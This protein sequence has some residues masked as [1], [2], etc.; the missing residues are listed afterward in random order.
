[1]QRYFSYICVLSK[2]LTPN[3]KL[4]RMKKFLSILAVSAV[5][6][7]SAYAVATE[8]QDKVKAPPRGPVSTEKR[9][10]IA[11]SRAPIT[12]GAD[13][14]RQLYG[15]LEAGDYSIPYDYDGIVKI[16][17]GG[18][19]KEVK[20]LDPAQTACYFTRDGAGYVLAVGYGS[21]ITYTI[22]EAD[23]W[24][25]STQWEYTQ[26]SPAVLP[27]D[28]AFDPDTKR[29]Y[30]YFLN[31]HLAEGEFIHEN[32]GGKLGYLDIKNLN[33]LDAVEYVGDM[34]VPMRGMSFDSTGQLYGIG[35]DGNLYK[36]NKLNGSLTLVGAIEWEERSS[37]SSP[38]GD[39]FLHGHESAEFD[40]DTNE[41]YFSG[42]DE[43]W[44]TYIS[45]ID[46]A[47]AKETMIGD[48]GYETGGS[49]GCEMF[50]GIF[51][52]Q[53]PPESGSQPASVADLK[54]VPVG[55]SLN[56]T[57]AFTIPSTDVDGNA[58]DGDLY[59]EITDGETVFA[60]GTA[61]DGTSISTEVAVSEAGMYGLSVVLTYNGAK[62]APA[63]V[64]LFIGP[65][66]PVLSSLPDV[67]PNDN[68]V[69]ILWEDAESL[70]GGNLDPLTYK[71]V[72][73]P[74]GKV[75]SEGKAET[76]ATDIVESDLKT[77]CT[78]EVT[79]SAGAI[80]GETVVSRPIYVGKYFTLPYTDN[81]EDAL[82]FKQYPALDA[83]IDN[84]T[85]WIDTR[86]GAA[87][88]SSTVEDNADDYL[89]IG[90]FKL[91]AGTN[92]T[93]RMTA[94]GHS[95]MERVA[96]YVGTDPASKQS[97]DNCIVE[98]TVINPVAG[99]KSLTGTF[100]PDKT[101]SYWFGI[102]ACSDANAKDLYIYDVN[103][104]GQTNDTPAAPEFTYVPAATG[105]EFTIT[106]PRYTIS[107]DAA[108]RA[109]S[110]RIYRNNEI[111]GEVT[112][113]VTDGASVKF[114]DNTEGLT[115][116]NY[117]YSI[118]AVNAAGEGLARSQEIWVGADVPGKPHNM[119]VCEDINTPGLIHVTWEAPV[120]GANGGYYDPSSV[121]Y[122]V[123]WLSYGAGGSGEKHV[124]GNT[125]V[126]IELPADALQQQG[127]IAISVNASNS[128]GS[129]NIDS[130]MTRSCYYGPALDLPLAETF[131][132]SKANS[133]I[134]SGES[135]VEK[136]SLFDSI[137][138]FSSSDSQDSDGS[139]MSLS[140]FAAGGGYRIRTPRVDISKAENPIL[141]F[142][143]MYTAAASDFC[144]EIA[145][146]DQPFTTLKD[147][148]LTAAASDQWTRYTVPLNEFKDAKYVQFAF[149]GHA[150]YEASAFNNIDNVNIL[151]NTDADLKV[152]SITAPA[153][154]SVNDPLEIS[155]S[156]R[157]ASTKDVATG[158]YKVSL[159]KNGKQVSVAEEVGIRSFDNA[160]V[161]FLDNP[162]PTDP[163]NSVYSVKVDFESDN[164]PAD[165]ASD[166]V[167]V[168]ISV[169]NYP[170]PAN[171]TAETRS[172]VTLNWTAPDLSLI[173]R[174]SVTEGFDGYEPF[175]ISNIGEWTTYDKDGA[176]TVVMATVLGPYDYP[177]IGEP[178]AWQVM[179]PGAANIIN[180]AWYARSGEQMIVSFQACRDGGRDVTSN[181]WL[182]SPE[183]DT[184]AQTIS[185]YA[186][187]GMSSYAPELMDIYVSSTGKAVEDFTPLAE[188]V[189]VQH[190]KDW[191]EFEY[192]LPEGT[193]YFAIVHK[194]FDKLALLI[195]DITFVPA[196]SKYEDITLEGYRVY[197]DGL[198]I[199]YVEAGKTSYVD[200]KT[201]AGKS[202]TYHVT[203]V[204][205][206]GESRVSNAATAVSGVVD[207]FVADVRVSSLD[208]VIT[209]TG[210]EGMPVGVYTVDGRLV[211]ETP[212]AAV[213]RIPVDA[214]GVYIVRAGSSLSKIIVR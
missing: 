81:F 153:K 58:I 196:G 57:V 100:V 11:A 157:N 67:F 128:S 206:K 88:Y 121:T 53:A 211:A 177:H 201:E 103:I 20:A 35:Y 140:T 16:D 161:T 142:H 168:R 208:R 209:V 52:M 101:D 163:E 73:M 180:G 75:V 146:D 192:K 39:G 50:G 127:V 205:D 120:A 25:V 43:Y 76:E 159:Y 32:N 24:S 167:T 197:R 106:V 71:V 95:R 70:N 91:D 17:A 93:F 191:I 108:A 59:W 15:Y 171:L 165:N 9:A 152:L 162:V 200:T 77:V 79:P 78:Y 212:G 66:T 19:H 132:G 182:I 46:I 187:V 179:N 126:D 195:D 30:G 92:Y 138:D 109:T 156:I 99:S 181:D 139:M 72:R 117:V 129:A 21:T 18:N 36:I 178:M 189:E 110:V 160:T 65:D 164:N 184:A 31:N 204:W 183:L 148:D 137:W 133:G 64:N 155:V 14:S 90:P 166:E 123:D 56:A 33:V 51:F 3:L 69:T 125:S 8:L 61:A 118:A 190:S 37:G 203:A 188:N 105:P 45:K 4:R 2:T 186:R 68:E 145:V 98:E 207:T 83:N 10:A 131:A 40:W 130:R 38:A 82:L 158:E 214:D 170:A 175:I 49:E 26:N 12:G 44:D 176:P 143:H 97:F 107:G 102:H 42:M 84:N 115:A 112:D 198:R 111:V 5:V 48:F 1:M 47:T 136:E 202:Y 89:C 151:D 141:V 147:I 54:I 22:Y 134:W 104:T 28:L 86:R 41:L 185:F 63:T 29:V 122:M 199:D 74:D 85:W 119:R 96:A 34:S 124:G 174:E 6:G 213:T 27:Y 23:T 150:S 194:S 210:A 173:G 193:K 144:V 154:V 62:S 169:P 113:G 7:A 87:V 60:S 116:G 149:S 13:G 135:I 55:T 172:G 94:D 80:N 114:A